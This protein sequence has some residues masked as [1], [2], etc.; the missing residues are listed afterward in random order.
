MGDTVDKYS[1][2]GLWRRATADGTNRVHAAGSGESGCPYRHKANRFDHVPDIVPQA[3]NRISTWY[4]SRPPAGLPEVI[5]AWSGRPPSTT[6]SAS[7]TRCHRP[8]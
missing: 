5:L 2:A 4:W 7:S 3:G 1:A 8:A 6:W